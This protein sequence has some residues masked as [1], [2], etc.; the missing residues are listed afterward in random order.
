M[1]PNKVGG[2]GG[3]IFLASKGGA[4]WRGE[5]CKRERGG[6]NREI[7]VLRKSITYRASTLWNNLNDSTMSVGDFNSFKKLVKEQLKSLTF[8]PNCGK[9]DDFNYF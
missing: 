7:T 8:L 2:G 9:S 6:L 4:Y 5:A 3:N 1:G